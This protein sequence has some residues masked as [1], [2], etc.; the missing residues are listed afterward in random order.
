[1]ERGFK[2]RCEEMSRSLRAEL[3][4][5]QA[6]P[7]YRLNNWRRIWEYIFGRSKILD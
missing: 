5:D 7:R 3:G 6:L 4:L 1:M 2:T